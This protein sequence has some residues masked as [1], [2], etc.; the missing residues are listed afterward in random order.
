MAPAAGAAA[1]PPASEVGLPPP[2]LSPPSFPPRAPQG[3]HAWEGSLPPWAQG[4]FAHAPSSPGPA[5]CAP[6][7]GGKSRSVARERRY[8]P[9]RAPTR[10]LLT[11]RPSPPAPPP[12]LA[13]LLAGLC[14]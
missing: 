12:P 13:L 10:L 11:R 3:R 8:D 7:P 14:R 6:A 5:P 2:P 4:A 9:R 1:L